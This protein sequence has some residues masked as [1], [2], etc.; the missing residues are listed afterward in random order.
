MIVDIKCTDDSI[1]MGRIIHEHG[2]MHAVNFLIEGS[3]NVYNFS[4]ETIL[5][6]PESVTGF[7]D[8]TELE[9]TKLFVKIGNGYQMIDDSDDEDYIYSGSEPDSDN[10]SDISFVS[11]EENID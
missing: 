7:Y 6:S 2:G 9:D 11:D 1:Q 4:S 3:T 10:C 5:I 8:V